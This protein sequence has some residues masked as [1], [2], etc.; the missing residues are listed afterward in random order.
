M[1]IWEGPE[2][3]YERIKGGLVPQEVH[4]HEPSEGASQAHYNPGI[5]EGTEVLYTDGQK[6]ACVP[7][8]IHGGVELL[9]ASLP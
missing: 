7:Q 6:R 4:C 1:E 2:A 5:E 8:P 3:F 9:C